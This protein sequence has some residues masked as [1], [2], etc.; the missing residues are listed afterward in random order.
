MF[1]CCFSICTRKKSS[2][3]C[4]TLS[5]AALYSFALSAKLS[6]KIRYVGSRRLCFPH[7][8]H[9]PVASDECF[10]CRKLSG[11]W[12]LPSNILHHILVAL[13]LLI[14]GHMALCNDVLHP[15]QSLLQSAELACFLQFKGT[16]HLTSFVNQ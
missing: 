1:K 15:M 6:F 2:G 3:E 7:H 5:A 14:L 10:A 4:L 13:K 16:N 12:C 9:A 8:R 11:K